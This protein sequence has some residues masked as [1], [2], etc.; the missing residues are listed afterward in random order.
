VLLHQE[1]ARSLVRYAA[2]VT[3][4]EESAR[5][6]VQE[7]FLRYFVERTYGREI[8]NP[9]AWLYQVTRN[10]LSDRRNA[11]ITNREVPGGDLD[12]VA[13]QGHT[14]ETLA[15]RRQASRHIAANLSGRELQCL[16][17]RTEGLSYQEIGAA[18][19][20][21]IGTVGALLSRVH[22]KLRRLASGDG[23]ARVKLAAAVGYLVRG[24][25]KCIPN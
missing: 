14:P 8:A 23:A 4:D 19:D 2:S 10:Y 16:Q 21:R 12:R 7:V 3:G 15:E 9:R 1:Y 20:L 25:G 24:G 11:A 6:A 18:L 22:E 5:D 17:M 13:G